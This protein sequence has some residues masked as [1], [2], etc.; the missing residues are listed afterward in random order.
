MAS[1]RI[2]RAAP[3]CQ[4]PAPSYSREAK[5]SIHFR[6]LRGDNGVVLDDSRDLGLGPFELRLGKQFVLPGWETAVRTMHV[7]E[8]ARFEFGPDECK[9]YAQLA[10]VLRAEAK[11]KQTKGH[12]D[13]S[14]G[15]D[16]HDHGRAHCCAGV[17]AAKQENPDLV[18]LFN[19]PLVFELELLKLEAAGQYD[20]EHWELTI[21]ERLAAI[22]KL[23]EQGN[24]LYKAKKHAEAAEKYT[25]ALGHV[26]RIQSPDAAA[27]AGVTE[28]QVAEVDQF[29]VP[30]LLNLAAAKLQLSAFA[31]VIDYCT[32]A[33]E[34]HPD[35][36]KALFRR[37][38][39]HLQKGRDLEL[40]IADLS[41]ASELVPS[42][43]GVAAA[44]R[45]AHEAN[46]VA[47][48]KQKQMFA[49]MFAT[50]GTPQT[51]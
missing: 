26:E 47:A 7:G 3:G 40:A 19:I 31:E 22:P 12:A 18:A 28:K 16:S 35:H 20:K 23:K 1:K 48:S 15:H 24:A 37:G 30:C 43:T 13:H 33:L 46:Q 10:T 9:G 44:L 2:L 41:R 32:R 42:D 5:A 45:K 39:A 49:G 36:P 29:W 4:G 17:A 11:K 21:A 8:L 6:C 51:A 38:Q 27:R 14:D 34:R 25:Q 50:Q